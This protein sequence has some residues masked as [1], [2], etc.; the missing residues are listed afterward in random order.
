MQRDAL[1][2]AVQFYNEE[3]D[4]TRQEACAGCQ[5]SQQ[6]LGRVAEKSAWGYFNSS[7]RDG[8]ERLKLSLVILKRAESVLH[9]TEHV[10]YGYGQCAY[11]YK[12][13]VA[14][15]WLDLYRCN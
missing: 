10:A 9:K 8:E 12:Y 1:M 13:K 6:S 11:G 15:V 5:R 2:Q 3:N 7:L 14:S 4:G